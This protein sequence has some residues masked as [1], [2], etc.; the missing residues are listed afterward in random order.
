MTRVTHWINAL[1]MVVM[2]MSGL[3]I[4]NAHPSLYW[5][6]AGFSPADAWLTVGTDARDP[7]RGML[8]IGQTA[9]HTT[10]VL[11]VFREQGVVMAKA[12][13][14]W[15]TIPSRRDLASGRRWHFFFA[16]VLV[17]NGAIYLSTAIVGGHLRRDL[18]PARAEV[19]LK[20]LAADLLNHLRLR[21]PRGEAARH[22]NILQKLSYLAVILVLGPLIVLTGLTMSPGFNAVAPFLLDAFGG[23]QSARSLHFLAANLLL[24]FFIVHIAALL[25]VGVWN[26]LRSMITGR[27]VLTRKV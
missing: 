15:L 5:G 23:R 2:L 3:Q 27:F 17:I 22:Y 21:F 16:W 7:E 6:Q 8:R 4:F 1:T 14:G 11:G 9:I 20:H 25:A 18:W 24:L 19:S 26:E 13:P 10:G 12:M